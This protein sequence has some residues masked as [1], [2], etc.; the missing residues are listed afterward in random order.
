MSSLSSVA[1]MG[2][3]RH[4]RVQLR[5]SCCSQG[6]LLFLT[7]HCSHWPHLLGG[8]GCSRGRCLCQDHINLH[9]LT[10]RARQI[11]LLQVDSFPCVLTSL[12]ATAVSRVSDA[13]MAGGREPVQRAAGHQEEVTPSFEHLLLSDTR[14]RSRPAHP[15]EIV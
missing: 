5:S 13:G 1:V 6:Q 8:K 11:S 12:C 14:I 10:G 4:W 7:G 2:C 3:H 15:V 9:P